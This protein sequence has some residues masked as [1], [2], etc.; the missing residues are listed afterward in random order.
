[1]SDVGQPPRRLLTGHVVAEP[2]ALELV[3]FN[4]NS[5]TGAILFT[6]FMY[7]GAAGLLWLVRTWKIGDLERKAAM[8]S[9]GVGHVDGV[10]A[11]HGGSSSQ[12]VKVTPFLKR[13]F[14]WQKV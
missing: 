11:A 6:G 2:I 4:G 13:L 5:Y 7:I 10:A 8:K 9:A 14:A 3:S 12:D 1:L